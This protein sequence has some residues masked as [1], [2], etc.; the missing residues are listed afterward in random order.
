MDA[1]LEVEKLNATQQLTVMIIPSSGVNVMSNEEDCYFQCQEP[2]HITQH[3]P[4][5]RC[6]ECDKYGHIVMDCPHK[7]LPSRTPATHHKAD[8]GHHARSSS[9]HH[10]ED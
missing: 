6:Y 4:H 5:I 7:T 8:I 1:I 10:W 3:C 2:G 9:R